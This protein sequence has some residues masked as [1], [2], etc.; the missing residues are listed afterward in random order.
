[1]FAI[2]CEPFVLRQAPSSPIALVQR[3]Y[4]GIV[5][6]HNRLGIT[7]AMELSAIK[8]RFGNTTKYRYSP[9]RAHVARIAAT[10]LRFRIG[11][12]RRLRTSDALL[13]R[14]RFVV[15]IKRALCESQLQLKVLDL[16][17]HEA[18][19]GQMIPEGLDRSFK[20]NNV[21]M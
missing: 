17:N 12:G 4:N 7:T 19:L 14:V 1:M 3:S 20:V 8:I 11:S 2:I 13:E 10:G 6:G 9:S 16:I 18:G 5:C 15:V 21:C